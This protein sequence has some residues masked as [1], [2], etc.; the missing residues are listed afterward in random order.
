MAIEHRAAA[1]RV[2]ALQTESPTPHDPELARVGRLARLLDHYLVDP[3]LGL[4]VPGLGDVAGSLLGLYAVALA[5]QRRVSPVI[6]AR[7]LLNLALD[8]VLGIVPL[9]G[10]LFDLGFRAN[11]RNA[12]LLADRAS[13]GGRATARD[14]LLV[15]GAALVF[16]GALALAVYAVTA[17]VRVVC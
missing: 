10:D 13:H 17:L 16:V 3:I 4:L 1:A 5:L 11:Q 8:A 2:V 9:A 12:R 14:W 7:M 6:I 15:I